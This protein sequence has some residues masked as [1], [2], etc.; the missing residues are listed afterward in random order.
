ME[1]LLSFI[2]GLRAQSYITKLEAEALEELLFENK[3]ANS[4]Y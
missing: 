1:Q 3:Y 4:Y 2:A